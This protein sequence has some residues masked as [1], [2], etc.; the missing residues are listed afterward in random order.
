MPRTSPFSLHQHPANYLHQD[1]SQLLCPKRITSSPPVQT[2]VSCLCWAT[3]QQWLAT[4]QNV[5]ASGQSWLKAIPRSRA[6]P[7]K[8]TSHS[9]GTHTDTSFTATSHCNFQ[10]GQQL[11]ESDHREASMQKP[12]CLCFLTCSPSQQTAS[13]KV[14]QTFKKAARQVSTPV[15]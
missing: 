14:S 3:T 6:Q 1:E 9:H 5:A 11:A 10:T 7:H 15:K 13:F 2:Q 8:G 12:P 4:S